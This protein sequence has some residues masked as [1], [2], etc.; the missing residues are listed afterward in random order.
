MLEFGHASLKNSLQVAVQQV[1]L[2]HRQK[3]IPQ[4][5]RSLQVINAGFQIRFHM[6]NICHTYDAYVTHVSYVSYVSLLGAA[7]SC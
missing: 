3:R 2:G 7:R 6:C 1:W 4:T 5:W